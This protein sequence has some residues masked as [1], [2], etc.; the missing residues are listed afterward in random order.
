LKVEASTAEKDPS[1]AVYADADDAEPTR[2]TTT[3]TSTEPPK[4][5]DPDPTPATAAIKEPRPYVVL[6]QD[7]DDEDSFRL[8]RNSGT[9]DGTYLVTKADHA[10]E[11]AAEQLAKTQ[12]EIES[13]TLAA[14]PLRSWQPELYVKPVAPSFRKAA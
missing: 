4:Q 11:Q 14:V 12:P 10:K 7:P 6:E 2:P 1:A 3:S 8:V 9:E 13:V 5:P